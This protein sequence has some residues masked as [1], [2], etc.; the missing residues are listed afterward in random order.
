MLIRRCVERVLVK[1]ENSVGLVFV[2]V[3]VQR[4][5]CEEESES[6]RE[7]ERR[8]RGVEE[9]PAGRS[10]EKPVVQFS[11]LRHAAKL[12]VPPPSRW[13]VSSV[14]E[15]EVVLGKLVYVCTRTPVSV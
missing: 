8:E 13:R 3:T 11:I 15:E 14:E 10:Y 6:A 12:L 5:Q 4:I 7:R 1:R 2:R 9:A